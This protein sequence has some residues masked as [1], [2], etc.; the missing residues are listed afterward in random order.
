MMR[1][2]RDSPFR[3]II[4]VSGAKKIMLT[5]ATVQNYNSVS[6]LGDNLT[7]LSFHVAC[8]RP[9]NTAAGLRVKRTQ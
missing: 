3:E 7:L 2:L 1:V 6:M 5:A 8:V 4:S 9:G